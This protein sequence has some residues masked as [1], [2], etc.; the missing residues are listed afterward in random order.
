MEN[1]KMMGAKGNNAKQFQFQFQLQSFSE[2]EAR[3]LFHHGFQ[4][5][6]NTVDTTSFWKVVLLRYAAF[7][8]QA[9][10]EYNDQA[11]DDTILK[12]AGL[13]KERALKFYSMVGKL[14]LDKMEVGLVNALIIFT[15]QPGSNVELGLQ[16]A[17]QAE[18]Y[19]EALTGYEYNKCGARTG[20]K[21]GLILGLLNKLA[22]LV[23]V[24][25]LQPAP[26]NNPFTPGSA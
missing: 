10:I 2:F 4:V 16:M 3:V 13:D 5:Q 15:K 23:K 9:S 26:I 18:V 12:L 6:T 14:N 8:G 21:L 24:E 25:T 20:V 22:T 19:T 7:Y 1:N 17:Q 11:Y